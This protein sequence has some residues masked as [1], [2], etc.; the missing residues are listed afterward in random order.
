MSWCGSAAIN[1]TLRSD[2]CRARAERWFS[3]TRMAENYVRMYRHYL[4]D[5]QLPAGTYCP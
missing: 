4:A 1:R 3:H 5:G 2:A